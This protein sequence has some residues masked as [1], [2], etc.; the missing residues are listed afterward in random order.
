VAVSFFRVF[1][2]RRKE[3]EWLNKLG[4]SGHKLL[5]IKDSKYYFEKNDSTYSYFIEHLAFSSQSDLASEYY[6]SCI[7]RGIQPV[8]YDK[9]WVYFVSE[10]EG[11]EMGSSAYMNNAS[12]HFWKMFY[13][14]F[15]SLCGCVFSGYQVFAIEFLKRIGQAGDGRITTFLSLGRSNSI[16]VA[17]LNV[18]KRIGNYLIKAINGYFSIWT[19]IFGEYEPIAVLSVI[20]PLTLILLTMVAFHL[21]EYISYRLDIKKISDINNK[22]ER[23]SDYAE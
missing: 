22:E 13:Y 23:V 5:R 15:F 11:L 20:V 12:F 6:T 8:I 10:S 17:L 16:L 18:L 9:N 1:F 2:S 4:Q 14:F 19:N 7:G 3:C 21:N